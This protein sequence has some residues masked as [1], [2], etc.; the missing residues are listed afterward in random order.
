MSQYNEILFRQV[1]DLIRQD[2]SLWDQG[3]F[4]SRN[5]QSSCGTTG[6]IAGWAVAVTYGTLEDGVWYFDR[7]KFK[8]MSMEAEA[9]KL[10]GLSYNIPKPTEDDPFPID[11]VDKVFYFISD[12]Y[13]GKPV[14]FNQ[15]VRRIMDVT[16]LDLHDMLV[17]ED[18]ASPHAIAR[19]EDD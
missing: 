4:Q 16:K 5:F 11:E 19:G 12:D 15:M 7:D 17:D 9:A 10:L 13:T 18:F 14:T 3:T 1:L 8:D 2:P 6:C